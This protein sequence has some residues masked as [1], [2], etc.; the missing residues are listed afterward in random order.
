MYAGWKVQ[1]VARLRDCNYGNPQCDRE[2]EKRKKEEIKQKTENRKQKIK[3]VREA[4]EKKRKREGH[5]PECSF[6]I[7]RLEHVKAEALCATRTG[8]RLYQTVGRRESASKS[9]SR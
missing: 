9:V 1:Q 5:S 4:K 6:A 7:G 2:R 8:Q 3:M